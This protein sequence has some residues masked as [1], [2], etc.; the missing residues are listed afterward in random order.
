M[1]GL[2]CV[3]EREGGWMDGQTDKWMDAWKG[4]PRP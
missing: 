2:V 1:D 4:E 3:G